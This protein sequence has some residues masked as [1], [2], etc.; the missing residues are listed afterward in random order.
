MG[1][2]GD[3]VSVGVVF[4]RAVELRWWEGRE[5]GAG[6][7][8]NILRGAGVWSRAIYI[9][10][11]MQTETGPQRHDLMWRGYYI[12]RAG[13]NDELTN[14]HPWQLLIIYDDDNMEEHSGEDGAVK[15]LSDIARGAL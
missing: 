14:D 10:R 5:V 8:A 9:E 2:D 1:V 12:F 6:Q 4:V 11:T 13:D 15:A 7:M 3:G